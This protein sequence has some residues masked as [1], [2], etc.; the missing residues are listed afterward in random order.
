MEQ[1]FVK[2]RLNQDF[3]DFEGFKRIF[4]RCVGIFSYP[5]SNPAHPDSLPRP[6]PRLPHVL[7][8]HARFFEVVPVLKEGGFSL[9]GVGF[10]F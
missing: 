10:V 5:S 6:L 1:D 7:V 2:R 4:L 8:C 3:P 9:G